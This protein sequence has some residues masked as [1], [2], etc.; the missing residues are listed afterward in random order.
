MPGAAPQAIAVTRALT[1]VLR[2]DRGRLMAALVARL[3]D[4][5]LAEDALQEA[6][7]SAQ[8][9]WARSGLP[10]SPQGWLIKVAGRKA[11]DRLRTE[12][13]S[14][15]REATLAQ[16]AVFDTDMVV[17]DIP[18]ERLRLI[19]TC[20]HPALEEK[21]RVALTLRT[22]C[23]LTTEEIARL[24]L[25]AAPTMGQRL[26]RAKAKIKAAGIPF[27]VPGPEQWD[28]RLQTV[29]TTLYLIFTTG[30]IAGP[31]EPRDLCSEAIFLT[32]L[33]LSLCPAEAEIEGALALMLLTDARR[34]ARVSADGAT[35][36]PAEQDRSLWNTAGIR[37]GRA[38]LDGALSRKR[39]G[40]FQI[41]AA[42]SSC[43][44]AEEG[45][46]WPQIV[47]LYTVLLLLEPTP[48][49]R[50][51]HAVAL[52][53][54]GRVPA[55][56]SL[57][58]RLRPD[59]EGFQ[60]FHAAAAAVYAKAGNSAEA[61][62]NWLAALALT[63]NEADRRLLNK[64]LVSHPA[65]AV[66]SEEVS[67]AGRSDLKPPVPLSTTGHPLAPAVEVRRGR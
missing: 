27:A 61:R 24:F 64:F 18:D 46:D 54:T 16:L 32:R 57:I 65:T 43:Q 7:L 36:P 8:V 9:H 33:L 20:C 44:M 26:S 5:Q 53:E 11:L 42:I 21:S 22:V 28:A 48:I 49:V 4:F 55:A 1:Q 31:G 51:N 66:L 3:G 59:L 56:L 25:D 39:A 60:P 37:Q 10:A 17:E 34:A 45:P 50:L 52:S 58:G 30:Y 38:L 41:K 29:L 13:R 35:V 6:C 14:T 40:P 23:G 15:R 12:G 67:A 62:R 63:D 19:F 2:Q 47:D